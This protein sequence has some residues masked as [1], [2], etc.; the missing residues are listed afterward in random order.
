MSHAKLIAAL[1]LFALPGAAT[2]GCDA[3]NLFTF[4]WN[5]QPQQG[6]N[7]ANTYN[8]TVTNGAAAS[9]TITTTFAVNGQTSNQVA[10]FPMPVIAA[11]NTGT[12]ATTEYTLTVGGV[13]AGRT[14]SITGTTNTIAVN[15]AFNTPVRDVAFRMFDIDYRLNEYRDWVRIVGRNGAATYLPT[16]TRPTASVARIGPSATPPA[17]AAGEVLGT[18]EGQTNDDTGTVQVSFAQPVTSVE[19]RYGNYPLQAGETGT[20]QQWISIHDV[21][22]CPMPSLSVTKTSTPWSD[23]VNGTTNPKQVPGG[24]VLY[25]LTVANTGGSPVDL[26]SSVLADKL[27][28]TLS[29]Y[30]GDIDD[31]GPLTGNVAFVPGNSGLT[32]GAANVTYSNNGGTSYAYTPAAGYDANVSAVRFAAAGSMAANSSFSIRFRARVK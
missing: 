31:A 17:I 32:L 10:G 23:P 16:I 4:D 18:L 27:P 26:S 5:S 30:N 11:A 19:V 14:P 3:N 29:F 25:T 13:F 8:Y 24:D 15:F 22:F 12:L 20:G 6:L 28:S 9:R 2:A 21:S 1:T 7:Y